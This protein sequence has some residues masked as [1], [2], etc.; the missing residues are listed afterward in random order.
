[1]SHQQLEMKQIVSEA[2]YVTAPP[3]MGY[4]MVMMNDSPQTVQP[5]QQSKGSGG[6]LRGCLAAMCC[7]CVLDCVF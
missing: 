7:C 4:P 5:T 3:P 6:F 1:M 2:P